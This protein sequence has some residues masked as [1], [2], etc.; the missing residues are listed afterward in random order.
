MSEVT[1]IYTLYMPMER[2]QAIANAYPLPDRINGSVLFADISGFTA[3]TTTLVEELGPERGV[4]LLTNQLNQV[5]GDLINQVH[6]YRGSV[7][8]FA[9]DAITCWFDQDNGARATAAGIAMQRVMMRYSAVITAA[10]T[11]VEFGI[12]VAVTAG[13]ARRLLVGNPRINTMDVIAGRLLDRVAAAE[14]QIQQG[15]IIVGRE[16]VAQLGE[17]IIVDEW[18]EANGESFAVI[19][20]DNHEIEPNPWPSLPPINQEISRDWL[21]PPIYERLAEGLGEFIAELRPAVTFFLKFSGIDYD[22]DEDAG[23]KLNAYIRWVQS[24]LA[25]YEAYLLQITMGDKGS[26]LY[27]LFGAPTAHEDDAARAV[28]AAIDL[29]TPPEHLGFIQNVQIGISQGV[30][31]AGAY[32]SEARHTYAG[33]GD[34][35]NMA[36]RL[37]SAAKPGQ[38]LVSGTVAKTAVRYTFQNL[39]TMILKGKKEPQSVFAVQAQESARLDD[40]L[41]GRSLV[42]MVGRTAEQAYLQARL[43]Q[44]QAGISSIVIIEGEAGIGKSRLVADLQERATQLQVRFLIGL[45]DAIAQNT[46]YHAWRSVF[47]GLFGIKEG[48]KGTAVQEKAYTHLLHLPALQERIPLLNSVLP[49]N[50]PDNELTA[51][52]SGDVRAGNTRDILTAILAQLSSPL[53]LILEDAHWFDSASWALMEQ[54]RKTVAPLMLAIITRPMQLTES[55]SHSQPPEY[56]QLLVD[57]NTHHLHLNSLPAEDAIALVCRRLG[58][59]S[60]PEPVAELIIDRAEGHPFFSE[61]MAYALRDTGHIQIE[62]GR[63]HLVDPATRFRNLDFPDT[64]QG[65]ITSRVDRLSPGQQLTLKVASVIGRVF[66]YQTL[67]DIHPIVQDKPNLNTYLDTLER[68]EITPQETP[69]PKVSYIFKH[70]TFQEVAYNLLLFSQRRQLH[71]GIAEWLETVNAQDL[72][73]YFPLLAH[74]WTRAEVPEKAINYLEKAG[75]QALRNGAYREAIDFI[76]QA[77]T[78]ADTNQLLTDKAS[79]GQPIVLSSQ[80]PFANIRP[81]YWQLLLGEAHFG[82]GQLVESRVYFL[83]ALRLLGWPMPITVG[84]V[85]KSLLREFLHYL[86]LVT[87]PDKVRLRLN[88]STPD[89]RTRQLAA[90]RAYEPLG[91]VYYFANETLPAVYTALHRFILAKEAGM[92]TSELAR[93]YAS[94]CGIFMLAQMYRLGQEY[95]RQARNITREIKDQPALAWALLSTSV[96]SIGV[97]PWPEI[98]AWLQEAIQLNKRLQ[99]KR[100][101]GDSISV[102]RNVYYFQGKF[103]DSYECALELQ[104][105]GTDSGNLEHQAWGITGQAN[106]NLQMGDINTALSLYNASIASFPEIAE[107]DVHEAETNGLMA[108]AYLRQDNLVAAKDA[109]DRVAEKMMDTLPASYVLFNAFAGMTQVYLALWEKAVVNGESSTNLRTLAK[110]ACKAMARFARLH[111]VGRPRRWL[112]TGWCHSLAGS[113][114]KAERAWRKSLNLAQTMDMAYEEGLVH[115]EIGRHL[116]ISNPAR[117]NHLA[118]AIAIFERL[119][120]ADDLAVAV[121]IDS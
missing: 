45:G 119:N 6:R 27:T 23:H 62:N 41:K 17:S 114:R 99:D 40:S 47:L 110:K 63:C 43:E 22:Q 111:P 92:A 98:E 38:T 94:V 42:P 56:K 30:I 96:F 15:E 1:D 108:V 112:Y 113:T 11:A 18:R 70:I 5:Y 4:E 50:I 85:R 86:W 8:S 44:L 58:V 13:A 46:P 64:I 53:L 54:V 66:P 75:E 67:H 52:M 29:Q 120:A 73:P 116:D 79:N 109:A 10:N 14:Q 55:P 68:L 121:K 91:L 107:D 106:A 117:A 61:E 74:H 21:L 25:R 2:R 89:T 105:V 7:I 101:L 34:Q 82:L 32:G 35:V 9:G 115:V 90:A 118:E 12:K 3:L 93:G 78:L 48:D 72:S 102:L 81:A 19:A 24:V 37:M 31:Y 88:P 36:A 65:V 26:Y 51:Q 16:V 69:P 80:H 83:N 103:Q 104:K 28:A 20:N 60:L 97:T 33:L 77:L 87:L 76:Q 59:N 71:S 84:D 49:L 100:S 39:G 57:E 95:G